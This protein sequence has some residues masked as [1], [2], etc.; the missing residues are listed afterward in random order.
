ML[1]GAQLEAPSSL[2][3]C[4]TC[5]ASQA[6]RS[7]KLDAGKYVAQ[8]EIKTARWPEGRA[9]VGSAAPVVWGAD[10][11]AACPAISAEGQAAPGVPRRG[12]A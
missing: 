8:L 11:W 6:R 9:T 12:A 1:L 3:T 2:K 7:L 4:K 5:A 10:L